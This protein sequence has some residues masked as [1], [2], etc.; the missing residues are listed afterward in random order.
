V[1]LWSIYLYEDM[2]SLREE[3]DPPNF[4]SLMHMKVLWVTF[5]LMIF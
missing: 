1:I 5:T 3:A 2:I 4:Y